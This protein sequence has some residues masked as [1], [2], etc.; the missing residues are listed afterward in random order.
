MAVSA[1]VR[2]VLMKDGRAIMLSAGAAA[3]LLGLFMAS[4]WPHQTRHQS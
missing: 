2:P 1:A 3:G 4:R